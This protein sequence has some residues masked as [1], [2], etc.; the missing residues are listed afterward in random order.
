MIAVGQRLAGSTTENDAARR[1]AR[2]DRRVSAVLHT[3]MPVRDPF[4]DLDVEYP[5]LLF[6]AAPHADLHWRDLAPDAGKAMVKVNPLTQ[7]ER[8]ISASGGRV[9][10]MRGTPRPRGAFPHS[11]ALIE[12]PTGKRTAIAPSSD[13][14]YTSPK[15]TPDGRRVAAMADGTFETPIGYGLHVFDVSAPDAIGPPV[16]VL[17]G[18]LY[19]VEWAWSPSSDVLYVSGEVLRRLA[20]DGVYAQLAS[21]PDGGSLY[22]LRSAVDAARSRAARRHRDRP[23][24]ARPRRS[25]AGSA[26][27][28]TD[29]GGQRRGRRLGARLPVP[30]ARRRHRGTGPGHAVDPRWPVFVLQRLVVG[31]EPLGD[32]RPRLGGS[33]ASPPR[34]VT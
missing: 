31:V 9:V 33:D 28:W 29:G 3:W 21:S 23:G 25:R 6:S 12:T 2:R 19:P 15:I 16:E 27:A 8:S 10:V 13:L 26:A 24:A 7:N 30:A 17:L 5:R 11:I 34:Y 32:G 20:A 4:R 1:A 18:D 22:A 14:L